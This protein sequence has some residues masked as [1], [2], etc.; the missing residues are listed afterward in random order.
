MGS[1]LFA[2]LM[3]VQGLALSAS[4]AVDRDRVAVGEELTLTISA[5]SDGSGSLT[6]ITPSFDGFT[7]VRRSERREVAVTGRRTQV[8]EFQ[9]KGM[10]VGRHQLGPVQVVQGGVAAHTAAVEVEVLAEGTGLVAQLNPRLREM[11]LAV[12]PPPDSGAQITV[13]TSTPS[14]IVG[15]QVDVVTL[16]WFPRELRLR[17]RRQ[18][19][20]EPPTFTGVWNYPQSVPP[21]IIATKRVGESWFDLFVYHQV[22]FPI[23]SGQVRGT[24]AVLRFS[25]PLAFQFFSQEERYEL[26]SAIP[27]LAV[28]PLPDDG[29]PAGFDGAVGSGITLTREV[30]GPPRT[31]EPVGV[32]F[33]LSGRGNVALWPPPFIRWPAGLQVYPEGTDE[34]LDGVGGVLGGTKTFRYLVVPD[35]SGALPI[36]SVTYHYFDPEPATYRVASAPGVRV[37][38]APAL[39]PVAS[40]A[41]P[42]AMIL[43]P[44]P[45]PSW[46]IAHALPGWG[47]IILWLAPVAAFGLSR[48]PRR[49]RAVAGRAE[50]VPPWLEAQRHLDGA[51]HALGVE[52]GGEPV[53][54]TRALRGAGADAALA[55]R[56]VSVQGRLG[57][58]RFAPTGGGT[59]SAL[60]AE[61]RAT[62]AALV[63][64]AQRGRGRGA[65]AI[66]IGVLLLLAARSDGQG[67]PAERLYET[68]AFRAAMEAYAT[69]AAADPAVV[70]NWYGIGASAYRLGEDGIAAAAWTTAARLAPRSRTL[71]RA[72][73]LV[74]APDPNTALWRGIWPVTAE[75]LF[76]GA[77]L[78]WLATWIGVALSRRWRG[79]WVVVACGAGIALLAAGWLAREG[80]RPLGL[81][82]TAAPLRVSPHGRAP[83]SRDL[84][85]GT[86][87]RPT[88]RRADWTLV[89]AA[90]GEVGWI[91]TAQVAWVRE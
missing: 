85:V 12:P 2:T 21:G 71:A 88:T 52:A 54:L 13:L 47:W 24:P 86:A 75:E 65:R 8:W 23:T 51:L 56:V 50:R 36:P 27:R 33:V 91:P 83:G 69:R 48:L 7:V 10:T 31:G 16:A 62:S 90:T 66:G 28:L 3:L 43:A 11:L 79:R 74:P 68:G 34:K 73:L 37:P 63:R 42:P 4:A 67:V 80:E 5:A 72:L 61:A 30:D 78:L 70:A 59:S 87:V 45:P 77:T 38:V 76:L 49:E 14:A 6:L 84:P 64:L 46:R 41:E 53:A 26:K 1:A 25:V 81:V 9:L 82:A 57:A 32:R 55:D 60:L 19:T 35:S 15:Q 39:T 18:P 22:L 17:L 44:A 58:E 29:R 40:R 89:R 20:L